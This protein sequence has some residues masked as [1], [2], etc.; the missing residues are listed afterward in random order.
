M[1]ES[2]DLF[3]QLLA[4]KWRD[5]EFPISRHRMSIAHDLVEHK[6]WGVDGARIEST[7]LAPIRFTFTAPLLNYINPGRSEKWAALYPNQF[8][9]L[10]AAF[11]KKEIGELQ[12]I[13]F[14]AIKC[15]AERF[16]A[17]WDASRRGGVDVELS[18]VQTIETGA[19]VLLNSTTPIQVVDI[20]AAELD[21]EKTKADLKSLLLAA[22]LALPPYL[23]DNTPDLS[24]TL[25]KIKG[26]I[27]Q[28]TIA[29]SRVTG[30]L[31]AIE[32]Q[33]DRLAQSVDAAKSATT[34]PV[35]QNIERIKEAVHDLHQNLHNTSK[36][37]ALFTVPNDTTLAGVVQ[38]LPGE[39]RVSDV[40]KLNPALMR[41]PIVP[42]G[43]VVRYLKA[44]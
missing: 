9:A 26:A 41:N 11:Q 23:M 2:S 15:K 20:G 43:T 42:R 33:V 40:I 21:D 32:Y 36:A 8:R 1:A 34:W 31:D 4:A 27:D 44:A 5:V 30:Q 6:Y 14:G 18:F 24:T 37:I 35:T 3:E 10:L 7:G 16:D 13:E 28:V 12:H 25:N 22:G 38:Q 29:G 17:D 39:A 19:D